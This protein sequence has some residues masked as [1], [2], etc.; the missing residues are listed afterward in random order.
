MKAPV[1]R[2]VQLAMERLKSLDE[3]E[4]GLLEVV[5]CGVRAIPALREL[6]FARERSG[7]YQPRCRAVEALAALREYDTLIDFLSA[8]N[9]I[10]NPIE[11]LGEDAVISAAARALANLREERVFDLL[12][13]VAEQQPLR[14]VIYALGTFER[15]EAIPSLVAAL[16]EDECRPSAETALRKIGARACPSLLVAAAAEPATGESDTSLRKRRSALELLITIGVESHFWPVLRHLTQHRDAEV[17]MLA[18]EIALAIAPEGE[19]RDA[20][21]RLIG[22]LTEAEWPLNNEIEQRILAHSETARHVI[23]AGLE[24][25]E[26]PDASDAAK[27]L[28][29]R[30]LSRLAALIGWRGHE[31][32]RPPGGPTA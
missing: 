11:R 1:P 7:I 9:E 10:S 17:S 19:K 15:V 16:A 29:R 28:L 30:T 2:D 25:G 18:C 8:P 23:A 20:V 12:L 5:T 31:V 22:L 3:G 13:S 6:L 32:P 24:E 21:R 26:T 4:L 27:V 14:G